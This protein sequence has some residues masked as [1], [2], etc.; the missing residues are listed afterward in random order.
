[1]TVATKPRVEV[2]AYK[3]EYDQ[4]I[5]VLCQLFVKESLEEYGM[6][7]T[8]EKFKQML[9]IC[10]KISFFLVNEEGRPVGMIA[11]MIVECITNGKP[12][13]Q[14]VVWYV[15]EQY[16]SNGHKLLKEMESCAKHLGC[17]SVVMGLMCNSQQD[18]LD[19]VYRRLGY[20]PFEVQYIKELN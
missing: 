17:S 8:Y 3:E 16:R 19:R 12:C 4:D 7:V 13:L 9:E 6:N 11:G 14:E 5:M 2:T 1:M 20:K 18:R 15:N 10:K